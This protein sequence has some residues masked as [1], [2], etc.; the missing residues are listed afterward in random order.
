MIVHRLKNWNWKLWMIP[1]HIVLKQNKTNVCQSLWGWGGEGGCIS[2]CV[3]QQGCYHALTCLQR[4]GGSQI[5]GG[6]AASGVFQARH[7]AHATENHLPTHSIQQDNTSQH[8]RSSPL[9]QLQQ[10]QHSSF[11]FFHII[12]LWAH[13]PLTQGKLS[14][15]SFLNLFKKQDCGVN[16]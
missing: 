9:I 2:L 13:S 1:K 8:T 10:Q 3:K 5:C 12:K 6:A 4:R 14:F 11:F 7:R 16:I 15:L